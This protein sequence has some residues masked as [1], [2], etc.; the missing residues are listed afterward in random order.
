MIECM[1]V[2]CFF[3]QKTAYE[4]RSSDWSS[5]VCSS[6]LHVEVRIEREL[7][8]AHRLPQPHVIAAAL[9]RRLQEG[10]VGEVQSTRVHVGVDRRA[11]AIDQAAQL[12]EAVAMVGMGVGE[13]HGVERGDAVGEDLLAQ[14]GGSEGRR[15][16][17]EGVRTGRYG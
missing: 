7:R 5:D 13:Q 14:V 15:V 1:F 16:G 17:E 12:V 6:D 4:M 10:V 3:K 2:F 9:L 8:A 11:A